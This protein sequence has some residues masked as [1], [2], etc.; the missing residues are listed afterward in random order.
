MRGRKFASN[1]MRQG[2]TK[3]RTGVLDLKGSSLNPRSRAGFAP[4]P[5]LVVSGLELADRGDLFWYLKFD[6]SARPSDLFCPVQAQTRH[7][8]GSGS[9]VGQRSPQPFEPARGFGPLSATEWDNFQIHQLTLEP[10]SGS[11]PLHERGFFLN[12][13]AKGRRK[14]Q[15]GKP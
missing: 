8:A 14:T 2:A 1:G 6:P 5:T 4:P 13:Y 7:K 15:G 3:H 9:M 11:K 10:P 12:S